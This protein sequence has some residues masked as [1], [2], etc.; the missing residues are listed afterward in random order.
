AGTWT[1][2]VIGL[3]LTFG[4]T[5]WLLS[6]VPFLSVIAIRSIL[7]W[8]FDGIAPQWLGRV[9]RRG[10][11]VNATIACY[12]LAIV[13]LVVYSFTDWLTVT[14][15]LLGFAITLALTCVSAIVFPFRCPPAPCRTA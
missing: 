8:S 6:Y 5:A 7:A 2:G 4:L 15:P 3:L 10:N 12:L 14:T 13:L 11:P 1:G 9:D